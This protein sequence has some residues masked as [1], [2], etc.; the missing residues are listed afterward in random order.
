[1][2]MNSKLFEL[3]KDKELF[4]IGGCVRDQLL[5]LETQDYDF[6]TNATPDETL[7][8]L[9]KAGYS[10]YDVGIV[11]GTV[12][13]IDDGVKYEITTYRKNESYTRNNR[14]P[15]VEWGT[16]IFEDLAR[17]DLTINCMALDIKKLI[18]YYIIK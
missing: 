12:G 1:M 14:H 6:A 3:F 10:T 4:L 8:I 9:H 2:K 16:T 18:K 17:R 5:G 7:D 15:V 13:F 11:F